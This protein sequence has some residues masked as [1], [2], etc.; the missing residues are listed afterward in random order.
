LVRSVFRRF[1]NRR[2]LA[3]LGLTAAIVMAILINERRQPGP[4]VAKVEREVARTLEKPPAVAAKAAAEPALPPSIQAPLAGPP[5]LVVLCDIAPDALQKKAFDKLLDANAITGQRQPQQRG[6]AYGGAAIAARRSDG[7]NELKDKQATAK[8][9]LLAT[10]ETE[11]ADTIYVEAT[12][13]QVKA[14]L[15][16]LAAQPEVFIAVSAEPVEGRRAEEIVRQYQYA[17]RGQAQ[18]KSV[19]GSGRH[20]FQGEDATG[21]P[22][23]LAESETTPKDG[24][25][26]EQAPGATPSQAAASSPRRPTPA[27]ADGEHK[28]VGP[29]PKARAMERGEAE[30]PA[31]EAKPDESRQQQPSQAQQTPQPAPRQQVLFVFRVVGGQPPT[32]PMDSAKQKHE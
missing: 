1:V 20:G 23:K 6:P 14:V 30:A 4:G 21:Q 3:W 24:K 22:A 27:A 25:N 26:A 15:A 17:P 31:E 13:A 8:G 16:G 11:A 19:L 29:A 28:Q 32:A 12:P 2:T 18:F 5:V 9:D 10:P 7:K